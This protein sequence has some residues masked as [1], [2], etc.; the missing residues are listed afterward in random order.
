MV[1]LRSNR[2]WVCRISPL[3]TSLAASA[4]RRPMDGIG[5]IRAELERVAEEAVAQ[6]HG[7]FRAPLGEGGRFAAALGRAVHDVVVDQ[8]GEMDQLHDDGEVEVR[9][10]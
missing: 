7:K 6:Q 5:E 8:R 1:S 4:I 2:R 9:R 3:Q 10:A